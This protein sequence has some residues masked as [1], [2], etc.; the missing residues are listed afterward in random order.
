MTGICDRAVR[1]IRVC[2]WVNIKQAKAAR[3]SG[4]PRM[5]SYHLNVALECRR[6]ARLLKSTSKS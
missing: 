3:Q 1:S 2:A 6:D 4:R 5:A